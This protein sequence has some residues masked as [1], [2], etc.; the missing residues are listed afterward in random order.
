MD[1]RQ[2]RYFR[3]IV[4]E[5]SFTLAS[6]GLHVAQ[7]ALSRQIKRL[8]VELGVELLERSRGGVR[9]TP[10]GALLLEYAQRIL[11]EFDEAF[12]ALTKEGSKSRRVLRFGAPPSI[13]NLV[14]PKLAA[15]Y[16]RNRK[17]RLLT[18]DVWS[19]DVSDRLHDGR[20]DVA[21]I[22]HPLPKQAIRLEALMTEP[23]YLIGPGDAS[24]KPLKDFRALEKIPLIG[25]SREHGQRVWLEQLASDYGI[26]LK[27][28]IEAESTS[29]MLTMV[30]E[31]LGFAVLPIGGVKNDVAEGRLCAKPIPG[32]HV[33]RYLA[34]PIGRPIS[35]DLSE[36]TKRVRIELKLLG[37]IGSDRYIKQPLPKS[38]TTH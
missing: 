36:L 12:D 2:L 17:V 37:R 23:V 32:V 9:M 19:R 24:I 4:E 21:I 18:V 38:A 34:L 15:L 7:P 13:G 11:R 30:A 3:K 5:G 6:E 20:L 26:K 29:G 27:V 33:T 8:E 22:T 28:D 14:F 10:S 16:N 25:M 1:N 35:M 31:H